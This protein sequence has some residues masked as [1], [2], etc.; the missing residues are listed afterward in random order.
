M[1]P[2]LAVH[3][4]IAYEQRQLRTIMTLWNMSVIQNGT[5]WGKHSD[6]RKIREKDVEDK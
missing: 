4:L 6:E 5:S 2:S 3:K 1:T